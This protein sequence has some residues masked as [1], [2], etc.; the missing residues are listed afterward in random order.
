MSRRTRLEDR[1]AA[2]VAEQDRMLDAAQKDDDRNLTEA[3]EASYAALEQEIETL[4]VQLERE[5]RLA[6]HEKKLKAVSWDSDD[7]DENLRQQK[8]EQDPPKFDAFEEFVGAVVSA[9]MPGGRVDPR[10]NIEAATGLSE[11]V[12]SDGGFLVQIDQQAGLLKRTHDVAKVWSRCRNIPISANANGVKINCINETSRA[13]GSRWGGIRA[14]WK[15]E[16]AAKTAS[17]PEFRQVELNLKKLVGLCYATDELLQDAAA[18]A[19]V[20][21]DGFV[22]EFGFKLDDAVINGTGAGQPLG[23]LNAGCVVSQ[24]KEVGQAAATL[25]WENIV[26]MWSRLWAP[27]QGNAVWLINQAVFP[28]LLTIA[29]SVGAGGVPVY[30]PPGGASASP[31]GLLL[32]RPVIPIEHC[33][34]IGTVGDII[35]GDFSQYVTCTK[36]G[37]QAASS[38]HLKFN[39]DETTFRWVFRA[40][41]QPIWN[42]A[43]T[44]YKD[45]TKTQSPFVTLATRA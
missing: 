36:G 4:N 9:S 5:N 34:A 43:L 29:Q 33:A 8:G 40:D 1:R 37:I 26:K 7:P 22:E 6:E 14:Y 20:L 21:Q 18:L 39:Y 15:A 45:A 25:V 19:S 11:G 24:A 10:L 13:D 32:G 30:L 38:I 41:G 16:A 44:P 23:I 17:T 31:Y 12:A 27:S 42:A 35:L 2:V 28:Q 3:E